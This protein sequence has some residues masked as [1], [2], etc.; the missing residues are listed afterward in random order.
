MRQI[1]TADRRCGKMHPQAAWAA[2]MQR[3]VCLLERNA[4]ASRL[5]TSPQNIRA[6]IS[7][8]QNEPNSTINLPEA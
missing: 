7:T 8:R 4:D 2:A 3:A 1:L 6:Q 5:L